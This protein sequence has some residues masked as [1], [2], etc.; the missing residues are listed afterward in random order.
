M[1]LASLDD[2]HCVC[3]L[4]FNL[5]GSVV[6]GQLVECE[7]ALVADLQQA[8][9]VELCVGSAHIVGCEL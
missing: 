6:G 2:C 7:H 8:V 4:Q 3:A 5:L 9:A 1:E